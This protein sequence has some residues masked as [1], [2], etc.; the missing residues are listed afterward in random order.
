[1]ITVLSLNSEIT[2]EK[3]FSHVEF[4]FELE[5]EYRLLKIRYSYSPKDYDGEDAFLLAQ[6]AFKDAYGEVIAC[7]E[8]II[9]ELP[10]KNHVTLSLTKGATLIGTAHRHANDMTREVGERSTV[11]FNGVKLEKGA[12]SIILSTH[13]VLSDK[14][15][16]CL[17]VDAYE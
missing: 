17:R 9:K 3:C 2:K 12:Y 16:F 11:G 6:E 13:A 5:K 10:L 1:M 4:P 14:I 7:D 15:T 8:Q